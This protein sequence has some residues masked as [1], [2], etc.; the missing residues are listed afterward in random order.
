VALLHNDFK[1]DNL[2][3]DPGTSAVNA[4][5]DWDMS[6]LG[7]P[8][9]DLGV[10]LSYWSEPDDPPVLRELGQ[11]PDLT[12]RAGL[13]SAY[14]DAAGVEAEPV[15]FYVVLAR[16]RLAIAWQQ[17]FV[18]HERGALT[19]P[20]YAGFNAMATEILEWTADTQLTRHT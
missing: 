3:F 20:R 13:A 12:D 15:D 14:F 2:L 6:T 16:F 10:T 17:M 18:L 19:G 8:L 9:F 5:V 1:F 4:V 7:D 11:A